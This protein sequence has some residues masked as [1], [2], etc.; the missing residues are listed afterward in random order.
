MHK[1]QA[2][3][4]SVY[5]KKKRKRKKEYDFKYKGHLTQTQHHPHR[6]QVVGSRGPQWGYSSSAPTGSRL[7][8]P[9]SWRWKGRSAGQLFSPGGTQCV[10]CRWES[11]WGPQRESARGIYVSGGNGH[12]LGA[13]TECVGAWNYLFLDKC[14]CLLCVMQTGLYV[15]ASR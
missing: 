9:E 1:S 5:I 2:T 12:R 8:A 14:V 10:C 15:S 11:L 6:R 13:R 3:Y 4:S 7:E